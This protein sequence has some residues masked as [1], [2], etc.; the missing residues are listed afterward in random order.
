M[1]ETPLIKTGSYNKA[2]KRLKKLN[3]IFLKQK[4]L[5]IKLFFLI[6][7][8]EFQIIHFLVSECRLLK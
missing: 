2:I 5:E 3:K 8:L 6:R 1:C 7:F 4:I